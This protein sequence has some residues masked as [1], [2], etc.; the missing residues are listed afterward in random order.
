VHRLQVFRLEAGTEEA[1]G[2]LDVFATHHDKIQGLLDCLDTADV[3]GGVEGATGG[4]VA[5]VA[6]SVSF[7]Q[8]RGQSSHTTVPAGVL[9]KAKTMIL[10]VALILHL[11]EWVLE[12]PRHRSSMGASMPCQ[13]PRVGAPS[14]QCSRR[15]QPGPKLLHR[16]CTRLPFSHSGATVPA[17]AVSI[18]RAVCI[19]AGQLTSARLM[20]FPGAESACALIYPELS[21]MLSSSNP[22]AAAEEAA[23]SCRTGEMPSM[24]KLVRGSQA[25]TVTHVGQR[26]W[27][28]AGGVGGGGV[29]RGGWRVGPASWGR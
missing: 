17:G 26:P 22:G 20:V 29:A 5:P 8:R 7:G 28:S 1:P 12:H 27:V 14:C 4:G 13:P 19:Q 10:E 25:C 23:K 24:N 2:S 18:H 21:R 3:K 11:A 16:G 9:S 6:S 15:L